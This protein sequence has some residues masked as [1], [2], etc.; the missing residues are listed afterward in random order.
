MRKIEYTTFS[1]FEVEE[2]SNINEVKLEDN[3]L[4]L[5]YEFK[6][7]LIQSGKQETDNAKERYHYI[8]TLE[9]I[10]NKEKNLIKK[11]LLMP[12]IVSGKNIELYREFMLN[13]KF[14]YK[15]N[16][17]CSIKPI[18]YIDVCSNYGKM[19]NLITFDELRKGISKENNRIKVS[20]LPLKKAAEELESS[21]NITVFPNDDIIDFNKEDIKNT[22]INIGEWKENKEP[23]K[24]ELNEE[25]VL[26][27]SDKYSYFIIGKAVNTGERDNKAFYEIVREDSLYNVTQE[28]KDF[29]LNLI[30]GREVGFTVRDEELADTTVTEELW[31]F[32]IEDKTLD[33]I[34]ENCEKSKFNINEIIV[35][36]RIIEEL[37]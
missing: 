5:Y 12:V 4:Y 22:V 6:K 28:N 1:I 2:N 37:N 35:R 23:I 7:Y 3:R 17:E 8:E 9:M 16:K 36:E 11:Y 14:K 33:L 20:L 19:V 15:N 31:T 18:F 30:K 27:L 25:T 34:E 21:L 29:L 26:M 13:H 10:I 24:T 32:P